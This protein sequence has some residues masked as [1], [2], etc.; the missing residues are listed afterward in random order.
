MEISLEV[1][2]K[3]LAAILVKQNYPLEV[4][5]VSMPEAIE[6]GQVVVRLTCSGIC[7]SQLGEIS[8]VKGPDAYLPHLLGHEGHGVVVQVGHGVRHVQRGD[9]VVLHWRRGIGEDSAPPKYTWDGKAINAGWVTTFNEWAVVSGNRLTKVP[10][11]TKPEIAALFGCAVTTGLGVAENNAQVR[12]GESVLVVGAGG[13]GL[14]IIQ[15]ASL[16]GADPI[17]AV[18][19]HDNRLELARQV[20]AT[21][22]L[23][24]KDVG[25][26]AEF[27]KSACPNGLDVA[28]DNSGIPQVIEKLYELVKPHG[29]VVLVG[30]PAKGSNIG[31]YSL[32]LHFGK[33]I[34]GSHGGES[35][36]TQDIPRYMGLVRSGKLGIEGLVTHRASLKDINTTIE[37]MR[38]GEISGRSMIHFSSLP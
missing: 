3:F 37:K 35:N 30:V 33:K 2:K 34:V 26:Y 8:G 9:S 16:M 15:G 31:I 32:P 19:L 22:S 4:G 5:E 25:E 7:G 20:G 36:P 11:D 28:I 6:Y 13:V 14:N 12:L 10:Q 21:H 17:L 29:R 1:P 38:T 23:K 18:D 27:I 24:T